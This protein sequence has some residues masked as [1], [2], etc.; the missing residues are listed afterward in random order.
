PT[1]ARDSAGRARRRT[2]TWNASWVHAHP[3]F[4]A[5]LFLLA[6]RDAI[7]PAG[8]IVPVGA[9]AGGVLLLSPAGG[10][11]AIAEAQA[12]GRGKSLQVHRRRRWFDVGLGRRRRRVGR[13]RARR[14]WRNRRTTGQRGEQESNSEA[15]QGH[16]GGFRLGL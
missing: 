6:L 15:N 5:A 7:L 10:R 11:T 8:A 12:I 4:T 3:D 16:R 2:A 1:S 9:E 13:R 14:R